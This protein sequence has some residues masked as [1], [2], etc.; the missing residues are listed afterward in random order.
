MLVPEGVDADPKDIVTSLL[1][2]LI[3][4][5]DGAEGGLGYVVKLKDPLALADPKTEELAEALTL[6]LLLPSE[7]WLTF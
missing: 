3:E 5:E 4:A 7:L 1:F 2:L 6:S